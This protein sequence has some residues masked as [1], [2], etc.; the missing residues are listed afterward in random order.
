MW[1]LASVA[2]AVTV[3]QRFRS[4]LG[5]HVHLRC[6]RVRGAGR[7]RAALPGPAAADAGAL[8]CVAPVRDDLDPARVPARRASREAEQPRPG[9]ADPAPQV[10]D[11]EGDAM[12]Q[13][14]PPMTPVNRRCRLA[15][16]RS[17]LQ[18]RVRAEPPQRLRGDG[19]VEGAGQRLPVMVETSQDVMPQC[20]WPPRARA[21]TRSV[22]S[23]GISS[24]ASSPRARRR[25]RRHRRAAPRGRASPGAHHQQQRHEGGPHR[26][27]MTGHH[28][29][30]AGARHCDNRS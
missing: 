6:R 16:R 21:A 2:G 4:D 20:V 15:L 14:G 3:V 22:H 24:R 11:P 8:E 18:V 1:R 27:V 23:P 17:P 26:V 29:S 5:L 12:P 25:H 7:R 28:A 13:A 10:H 9:T 30:G 19:D